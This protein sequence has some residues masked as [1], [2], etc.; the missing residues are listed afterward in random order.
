MEQLTEQLMGRFDILAP[1][2]GLPVVPD[3]IRRLSPALV[4]GSG[5]VRAA[6]TLLASLLLR[7]ERAVVLDAANRFDVYFLARA[8]NAAGR[9]PLGV[10][11]AAYVSRAFTFQQWLAL[12]ETRARAAAAKCGARWVFALGPLDLLTDDGVKEWE[13]ELAARRTAAALTALARAGLGVVAAQ[14]ER[15]LAAAPSKAWRPPA[16]LAV[17]RRTRL[18]DRLKESCGYVAVLESPA[19]PAGN[20]VVVDPQLFLPLETAGAG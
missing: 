11:S 2:L 12:L 10:L 16:S 17:A 5:A 14:E 15:M 7:G 3:R 13:A 6:H 18:L 19:R 8:A 9:S 4:T 20:P 1:G